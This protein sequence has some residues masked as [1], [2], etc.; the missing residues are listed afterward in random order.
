MISLSP[1]RLS[2]TILSGDTKELASLACPTPELDAT[3]GVSVMVR[4][5]LETM[6]DA[7]RGAAVPASASSSE[8]TTMASTGDAGRVGAT[9]ATG[10]P[11]STAAPGAS[12]TTSAPS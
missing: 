10:V 2:P 7:A 12:T 9:S 4:K 11:S 5:R 8:V 6:G 3:S 1:S